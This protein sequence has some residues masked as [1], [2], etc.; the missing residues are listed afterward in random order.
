MIFYFHFFTIK[1]QSDENTDK[2]F[3]SKQTIMQPA[4]R[5]EVANLKN[6]M[7]LPTKRLKFSG[8]HR[9]VDRES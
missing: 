7:K 1:N 5:S 9:H 3:L 4:N 8:L 6:L 2:E